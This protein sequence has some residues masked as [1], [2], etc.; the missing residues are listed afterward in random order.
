M[1][2]AQPVP[3]YRCVDAE[4]RVS[5]QDHP[6]S[7]ASDEQFRALTRP[8]AA[9]PGA[10]PEPAPANP[11]VDD[12]P[13]PQPPPAPPPPPPPLWTCS[14]WKGE[15]YE[16]ETGYTRPRCV[17]LGVLRSDL[18]L[19]SPSAALCQWVEDVCHR[20]ND[21]AACRRWREKLPET[22]RELR[23]AAS[24]RT[25]ALRAEIARIQGIL[26]DSCRR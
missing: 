4:G 14:N 21:D 1:L 17:P 26:R 3:V 8:P 2:P 9:A 11:P 18:P 5:F 19:G 13:L 23:F 12:P 24:D 7:P 10:P 16:S 15:V 20:L 6:C 22:E 25:A